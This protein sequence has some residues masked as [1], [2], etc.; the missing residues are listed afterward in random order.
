MSSLNG[1]KV[2]EIEGLGPAPV[3]GM[4][5]ADMGGAMMFT[6]FATRSSILGDQVDG[7][8]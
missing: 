7:L 8:V 4:M 2:V 6:P 5:L 1:I 3:A